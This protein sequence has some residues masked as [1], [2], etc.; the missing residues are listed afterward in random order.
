[1]MIDRLTPALTSIIGSSLD[2]PGALHLAYDRLGREHGPPRT[3]TRGVTYGA[4]FGAGF[5]LGLGSVFGL[6]TGVAHGL[7]LASFPALQGVD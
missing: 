5:G 4:R 1:M 7:T 3:L 2:V 6:T